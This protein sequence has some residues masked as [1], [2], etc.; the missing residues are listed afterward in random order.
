MTIDTHI[1]FYDPRRPEGVPWPPPE[2]PL[3]RP[4][5][6]DEF[7][8]L[9]R[10]NGVSGAV[11]VEASA[12][13]EDNAWLLDIARHEPLVAGVVGRLDLE[14]P[15]FAAHLE[16]F[17]ADP[18]F[19]G[20][21]LNAR[22]VTAGMASPLFAENLARLAEAGL[23]LDLNVSDEALDFVLR[24]AGALP[25]LTLVVDHLGGSPRADGQPAPQAREL[26]RRLADRPNLFCKLS[27][28]VEAAAANHDPVP[29]GADYYRPVFDALLEA[30]GPHRLLFASNWPVSALRAPYE[31]VV[32]VLDAW[33]SEQGPAEQEHIR[34][35]NAVIAY[36]L[37]A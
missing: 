2:S 26:L 21:R 37:Q 24:A 20:I 34:G 7:S 17:A 5:L 15:E 31:T 22:E 6:P 8:A 32:G 3:Y 16:R 27:G 29:A 33:I 10:A 9:A 19:R 30:M 4:V 13:V 11:V 25:E 36:R 28:F 23:T 1:H 18:A 12:W 35:G 14:G